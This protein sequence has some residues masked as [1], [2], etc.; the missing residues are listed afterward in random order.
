MSNIKILIA[1]HKDTALL[2]SKIL[3][4]IQVGQLD[5]QDDLNKCFQMIQGIRYLRK[6][7]CIVN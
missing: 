7:Q 4:P 5:Q 1:C 2:D 6:I 3:I